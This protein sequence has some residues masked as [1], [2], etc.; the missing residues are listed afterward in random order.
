[1]ASME[2]G[3]EEGWCLS[4]VGQTPLATL[5]T[6]QAGTRGTGLGKQQPRGGED[7]RWG[8]TSPA[9]RRQAPGT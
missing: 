8:V 7:R 3:P 1:M 2:P 5:P 9:C 4:K 6:P